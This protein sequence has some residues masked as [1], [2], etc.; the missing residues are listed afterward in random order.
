MNL[1][2]ASATLA[3]E[4]N[5]CLLCGVSKLKARI[6]GDCVHDHT[7]VLAGS[8]L[9][10]DDDLEREFEVAMSDSLSLTFRV[11]YGVLRDRTDAED[12]T[13]D[14]FAKA[15]VKFGGLRDRNAF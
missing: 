1:D 14:A 7:D 11:A 2:R 10:V 5:Q 6:L 12:V 13:Q 3:A 8:S 4:V 15:Y 9:S